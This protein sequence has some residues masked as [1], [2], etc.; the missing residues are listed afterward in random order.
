MATKS[1]PTSRTKT[2]KRKARAKQVAPKKTMR[3]KKT[4]PK[5]KPYD[6]KKYGGSVPAFASVVAEEMKK[7]RDDR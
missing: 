6:A 2:A 4:A 3:V 1:K 7:W 5:V